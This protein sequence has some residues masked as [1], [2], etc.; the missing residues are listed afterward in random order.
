[1]GAIFINIKIFNIYKLKHN[2]IFIKLYI[3]MFSFFCFFGG[4]LL[5]CISASLINDQ[6]ID[7]SRDKE[8]LN[9]K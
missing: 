9:K 5:C 6:V 8:N 1:M 3:N 4:L 2:N 7:N